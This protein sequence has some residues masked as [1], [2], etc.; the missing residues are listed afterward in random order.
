MAEIIS[1]EFIDELI[2]NYN[3]SLK[4][5]KKSSRNY[6]LVEE[7]TENII[8][9]FLN[10]HPLEKDS[11]FVIGCSTSEIAGG[12]I[13][14]DSNKE[15]GLTVFEAA[16]RV[17]DKKGIFLACQCCEHLNRALVIE[18]ECAEKYNFEPV[19]VVPW[20]HGGGAFATAA[21]HGFINPVVVEHVKASA[22]IDI[23]DTLIGM[24]LKDVVVPVHLQENAIGSAHVVAAYTRPKLIGGERARYTL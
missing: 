12:T 23:G 11:I 2:K 24:H 6:Q 21:Y 14:Q 5:A 4:K 16:H 8:S 9:N 20:L 22:G 18:K 1:Q 7:Q 17:L 10:E 15:I 3:K 19:C 13:G